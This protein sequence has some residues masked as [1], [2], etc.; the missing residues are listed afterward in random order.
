MQNDG[1]LVIYD[2]SYDQATGPNVIW[3]SGTCEVETKEDCEARAGLLG[4]LAFGIVPEESRATFRSGC[5]QT[6]EESKVWW[7]PEGAAEG[8]GVAVSCLEVVGRD[9]RD[10]GETSG[11]CGIHIP[12]MLL[13]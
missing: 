4:N 8:D 2:S 11:L 5:F 3:H 7:N 13:L 12:G 10:D 9:L 6:E 1:N